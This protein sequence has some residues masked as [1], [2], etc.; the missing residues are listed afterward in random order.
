MDYNQLTAAKTVSGSIQNW[1]N[2]ST[3][4]VTDILTESQ[5]WIYQRLRTREMTSLNTNFRFVNNTNFTALPADF[6]DPIQFLPWGWSDPLEFEHEEAIR[7]PLDQNG[8]LFLGTPSQWTIIGTNAYVD[9]SCNGD[10]PGALMYY[11]LPPALSG[12]NTTNFLTVRYPT[13]LRRTCMAYGYEF[14]KDRERAQTEFA[15][16]NMALAEAMAAN[17]LFRRTQQYHT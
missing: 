5:A 14:R 12:I 1:I 2:D 8:N 11:A 13:L 10:F 9:V 3:L 7:I 16:A 6:L 17:E 4:P 15:L